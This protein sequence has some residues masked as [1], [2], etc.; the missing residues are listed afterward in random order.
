MEVR[1]PD[2]KRGG[3]RREDTREKNEPVG[4]S[5]ELKPHAPWAAPPLSLKL[6]CNP[7]PLSNP[8]WLS[9]S[10]DGVAKG[11]IMPMS[12]EATMVER[13]IPTSDQCFQKTGHPTSH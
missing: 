5:Y 13:V 6:W 11:R 8:N 12:C 7:V 9:C 3:L 2:R 4:K 10:S 1:S